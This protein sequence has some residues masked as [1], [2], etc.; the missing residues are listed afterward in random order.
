VQTAHFING[1][2]YTYQG[3]EIVSTYSVLP[4]RS[5][6]HGAAGYSDL[7]PRL[8]RSPNVTHSEIPDV[9]AALVQAASDAEIQDATSSGSVTSCKS[10]RAAAGM[11]LRRKLPVDAVKDT[12]VAAAGNVAFLGRRSRAARRPMSSIDSGDGSPSLLFACAKSLLETLILSAWYAPL[13]QIW[14]ATVLGTWL[15]IANIA[16]GISLLACSARLVRSIV[17]VLVR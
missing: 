10:L 9:A 11:L 2:V 8:T 16:I 13:V 5:T 12:L 14:G 7:E 1:H 3:E 6:M 17:Q 4:C 15:G